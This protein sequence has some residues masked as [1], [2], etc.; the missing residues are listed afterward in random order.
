MTHVAITKCA[1]WQRM[2]SWVV[3]PS[4]SIQLAVTDTATGAWPHRQ[5]EQGM[6]GMWCGAACVPWQ[7]QLARS[8]VVQMSWNEVFVHEPMHVGTER[9][10]NQLEH[11]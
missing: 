3:Q 11:T 5:N 4:L 10:H 8:N 9:V 1:Q 6:H 7:L 2:N